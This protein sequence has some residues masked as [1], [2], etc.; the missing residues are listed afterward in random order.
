VADAMLL[1][2]RQFFTYTELLERPDDAQ[3]HPRFRDFERPRDT[4]ETA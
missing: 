2:I 3:L 1:A 4:L